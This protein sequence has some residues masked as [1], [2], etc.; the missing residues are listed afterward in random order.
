[1]EYEIAAKTLF[2]VHSYKDD[3]FCYPTND[4]FVVQ[5]EEL[6]YATDQFPNSHHLFS[7][8]D[9][10]E[11]GTPARQMK[12]SSFM[13]ITT[14]PIHDQGE[15]RKGFVFGSS[16]RECDIL[17]DKDQDK[18]VSRK[19]FAVLQG[20]DDGALIIRNLSKQRTCIESRLLGK[21]MLNKELKL[22]EN[23]ILTVQLGAFDI[24]IR[25]PDHGSHRDIFLKNWSEHRVRV[26]SKLPGLQKLA[27]ISNRTTVRSL[28]TDYILEKNL[29]HGSQA[30]V[31]RARDRLNG[32][33]YAIKEFYKPE[34]FNPEEA[35]ILGRLKHTHIIQ[36]HFTA[37]YEG[38]P[39]MGMEL[40]GGP[41]L[42]QVMMRC[43]LNNLE[44][45]IGLKQLFEAVDY[46][47]S[48]GITHR[49]IK[50][51]NIIVH[52]R[53]PLC[54]K[55]TDFGMASS[56]EDLKTF[57]GTYRYIA[58]ELNEGSHYSNK[59]DIW[60]LGIMALDFFYGLPVYPKN[61]PISNPQWFINIANHLASQRSKKITW[62]FI[63]SLL[64]HDPH[65]RSSAKQSLG[66]R[67]F[68]VL[69]KP[70]ALPGGIILEEPTQP[71][72]PPHHNTVPECKNTDG[73]STIRN[74]LFY[75]APQ[76]TQ[77]FDPPQHN[78]V[79]E[80]ENASGLSTIRTSLFYTAPQSPQAQASSSEVS[81]IRLAAG[82]SIQN[83]RSPSPH[84]SVSFV[85][86]RSG[87]YNE[88]IPD[89]LP[90][91]NS[92]GGKEGSVRNPLF[93]GSFV[94]EM[95]Q[96]KLSTAPEREE[97]SQLLLYDHAAQ[98]ESNRHVTNTVS[99]P[100]NL[101]NDGLSMNHWHEPA[102]PG[103]NHNGR[104][105]IGTR[106]NVKNPAIIVSNA[107]ES[108][109][110][111]IEAGSIDSTILGPPSTT[112]PNRR[113]ESTSS[114]TTKDCHKFHHESRENHSAT[115]ETSE[116]STGSQDEDILVQH[117]PTP[118][119]FE[120]PGS[121]DISIQYV[122]TPGS[123]VTQPIGS[124]LNGLISHAIIGRQRVSMRTSDSYL[125][126]VEICA[127]AGLDPRRSRKYLLP[128]KN[129]ATGPIEPEEMWVPFSDGLSLCRTLRLHHNLEQQLQ[130]ASELP[131]DDI[132]PSI[133]E[134]DEPPQ[135]VSR[136]RDSSKKRKR[137][138]V[139]DKAV[140][141]EMFDVNPRPDRATCVEIASRTSLD[142][143]QVADWF[144]N[145]ERKLKRS[146]TG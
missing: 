43:P 138:G 31:Y 34:K 37:V 18:G 33:L 97:G 41:D 13:R 117:A 57:V 93:A 68:T 79:P 21:I 110:S 9:D 114:I 22:Q 52:R 98:F 115:Y 39:V 72:D 109:G 86:S 26:S 10:T 58:P 66:H 74:S 78:T 80:F 56:S 15:F 75:R 134:D 70:I 140:L 38:R 136:T 129:R 90:W 131:R 141:K 62:L 101:D 99:L 122:P 67:F 32:K 126:A 100:A 61:G 121:E 84:E 23:E 85:P 82:H 91:D 137:I 123:S 12:T 63:D 28:T 87:S 125:N 73:L 59:V 111:D 46:L 102:F 8:D 145:Q 3:V 124:G 19:Q 30:T 142:E 60:S 24:Q 40:G 105:I 27:I 116:N 6:D 128:L 7:Y 139:H 53:T 133:E 135:P 14:D 36:V 44:L 83:T 88:S 2:T 16:D 144:R 94:T 51:S 48:R 95:G 64:Q 76:S 20:W 112:S 130:H 42:D 25:I 146:R 108:E 77:S 89:T 47:H 54:L 96:E 55:F 1:M 113:F 65:L 120:D 29:G 81:T 17:L 11:N 69:P 127:A 5:D 71:F 118:G 106:H 104:D 49:D 50:P 35:K 132:R 45:K 4:R 103:S 107:S 119:R 92:I 143:F